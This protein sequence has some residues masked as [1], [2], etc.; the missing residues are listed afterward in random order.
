MRRGRLTS[1]VKV[2]GEGRRVGARLDPLRV[3]V[4]D[5]IRERISPLGALRG[6]F[7]RVG[8]QRQR[9][10]VGAQLD[11]RDPEL[12]QPAPPAVVARAAVDGPVGFG[13]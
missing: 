7:D 8:E 10:F 4:S 9:V 13:D 5:R 2:Q 12:E 6:V 3:G 1:R 11:A